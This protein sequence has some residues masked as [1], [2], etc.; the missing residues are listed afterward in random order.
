[1][2]LTKLRNI[3]HGAYIEL[4]HW[5]DLSLEQFLSME[6]AESVRHL[7]DMTA[8]G[9]RIDWYDKLAKAVQEKLKKMGWRHPR[10]RRSYLK[11]FD[12][13]TWETI[14]EDDF[15]IYV[16]PKRRKARREQSSG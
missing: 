1:M 8:P 4:S 9:L 3:V 7:D 13:T 6:L 15:R 11:Q 2:D 14:V 12:E 16:R 5:H 10:L